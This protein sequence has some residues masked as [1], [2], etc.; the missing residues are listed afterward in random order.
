MDDKVLKF[1]LETLLQEMKFLEADL[2]YHKTLLQSTHRSFSNHYGQ[3]TKKMGVA[4]RIRERSQKN[5][6]TPPP[7]P[8]AKYKPSKKNKEIYKKIATVAHPDKLLHLSE[9]EREEKQRQFMA[10]SDAVNNNMMLTLHQIAKDIG[11]SMDAPTPEDIILFEAELN[12]LRNKIVDLEGNWVWHYASAE[13]DEQ[14]EE[15]MKRYIYFILTTLP[16]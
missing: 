7:P 15:I 5:R 10:A 4:E 12:T 14:K 1:K 6:Q 9:E 11:V 8:G 16:K 13:T 2:E 3:R